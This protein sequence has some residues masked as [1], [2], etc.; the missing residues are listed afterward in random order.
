MPFYYKRS[1]QYI[2]K[3]DCIKID[4][5]NCSTINPQDY[6]HFKPSK[7]SQN[8]NYRVPLKKCAKLN[9]IFVIAKRYSETFELAFAG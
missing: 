4:P 7:L 9:G 1:G 3:P 5:Q 8:Y 2:F 6:F